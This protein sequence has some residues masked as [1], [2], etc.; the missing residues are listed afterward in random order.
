MIISLNSN[1]KQAIQILNKHSTRTL[2]VV[3]KNEK[4]IGTLSDGNIRRSII[5]GFNLKTSIN[6]IYNKNPIFIYENEIDLKKL[7]KIFLK[8]KIYLIPIVNKKKKVIKVFYLEDFI[9]HNNITDKTKEELNN[10]G[11]VI[12]A[13]GKGQRMQ[14]YTKIFPKPLLPIIDETVIDSIISKFLNY[15]INN[16]Y[17]TINYKHKVMINHFEKYKSKIKFKLIREK[18]SLG[19]AG[20]LYFLKDKKEDLFFVSNCD[21]IVNE[22]YQNILKFHIRNKNDFTIVASKQ[23]ISF[24]YGVCLLDNKKRFTGLEEKPNYS[25]LINI[26]LYLIDRKQLKFIKKNHKLNMDELILKLKKQKKKIGIY[27]IDSSKWY[28]LGNW[29]SYKN[30]L[31]K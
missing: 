25:F 10:F 13:G 11:V 31:K 3:D 20:S 4:L 2:M 18:K 28:D 21:V 1:I 22:D 27:E 23:S 17:I 12:M 24:P 6:K 7:K 15:K 30:F 8:K 9:E 16:F 19:T 5:N 26:G 29:E 14:P